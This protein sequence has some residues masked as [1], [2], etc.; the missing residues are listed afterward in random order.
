MPG[1]RTHP[2]SAVGLPWKPGGH[3]Q[4]VAWSA[5]LHTAFAPHTF[6]FLQGSRK[7]N[8][9]FTRILYNVYIKY[10]PNYLFLLRY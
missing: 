9:Y 3:V 1:T 4:V 7:L 5:Q 8:N 2:C 10:I 6:S